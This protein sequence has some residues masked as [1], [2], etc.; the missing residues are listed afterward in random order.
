[1]QHSLI[2]EFAEIPDVQVMSRASERV[3][4]GIAA[5][6]AVQAPELLRKVSLRWDANVN[7]VDHRETQ[8]NNTPR[9]GGVG[10][11]LLVT[12]CNQPAARFPRVRP[13]GGSAPRPPPTFRVGMMS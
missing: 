13:L 4:L 8:K 1:M 3:H 7:F 11:R 6:L 2:P 5:D 12:A 9:H 10:C